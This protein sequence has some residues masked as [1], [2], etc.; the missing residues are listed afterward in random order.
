MDTFVNS[1]WYHTRYTCRD[2][3]TKILD[4]RA[5]QWLPVD[6]YF[7]G[8]EHAQGHLVYCR[9]IH[10]VLRDLDMFPGD[11]GDEPYQALLCQGMVQ[12]ADGKKMSKSQNNTVMAK[13]IL[14]TLG[15]DTARMYIIGIGNPKDSFPWK[16]EHVRGHVNFLA[17]LWR[18][19]RERK[20]QV[21]AGVDQELNGTNKLAL[22]RLLHSID[23]NIEEQRF[24]NL[25]FGGLHSL[26]NLLWE[27]PDDAALQHQGFLHLLKVLNLISPHIAD[28]LWH[29]LGFS[30]LLL[31]AA[32]W[33]RIDAADLTGATRK[34]IV[35]IN[36][37]KR[38]EIEV[39]IELEE[40]ALLTQARSAKNVAR[41]L[42]GKEEKQ[43]KVVQR[44][45]SHGII[46]FVV[47]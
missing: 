16:D 32:W 31:D 36:G 17:G 45:G 21:C 34:F 14:D 27:N 28:D 44:S 19:A 8:D 24:N 9:F 42:E 43:A 33:P 11:C 13:D 22:Y 23:H 20:E 12:G 35:Q 6:H 25:V 46:F 1:A 15:A 26:R 38:D 47:V 41:H 10:K 40:A 3:T 30:G 37:K 29:E 2:S 7:G 18:L 39:P 4:E 5:T